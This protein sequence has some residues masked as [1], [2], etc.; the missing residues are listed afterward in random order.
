T[1]S[2]THVYGSIGDDTVRAVFRDRLQVKPGD[3]LPVSVDPRNIHL[4]DKATGLP[5]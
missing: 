2:E 5:L 3:R 4:F 1:G